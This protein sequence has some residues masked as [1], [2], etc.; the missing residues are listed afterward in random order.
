MRVPFLRDRRTVSLLHPDAT[1]ASDRFSRSAPYGA[2]AY[3]AAWAR[4][5]RRLST[6]RRAAAR[7]GS[8]ASVATP[9]LVA[10]QP[11]DRP[12]T[13]R[14]GARHGENASFFCAMLVPAAS[15]PARGGGAVRWR[16][17]RTLGGPTAAPDPTTAGMGTEMTT[18]ESDIYYDPYDFEIDS[19]PYPVWKRLRDERPLYYNERY[20]FYAVSRFE[21]VD[22]LLDGLEDLH[23]RQGHRPRAD[24]ERHGAAARIDHLRGPSRP[25]PPP[26]PAVARVHAHA[27]S[28]T[29][30]PRSAEFCARSLDPLVGRGGSTSSPTSAPRCPCAPSACCWASPRQDQE[31]IRDR[32]D[33]GL[34]LDRGRHARPRHRLRRGHQCRQRLRRVHRLAGHPPV[35]RPDDRSAPGRVRGRDRAPCAGSPARRSSTTSTSSPPRATRPRPA[36]SDGRARCWPSTPTSSGELAERPQPGARTP[37]RSCCATSPRR[38]SRPATSPA[39][40]S[41]TGR[42]SRPA[43]R[44]CCSPPRRNRDERKFPDADRFDIHRTI[45]HHLAF[46]YGIHFCL[47]VGAG[48]ARGPRR[49]GRGPAALPVV[50]GRLGQCRPGPDLD[51]PGLG[52]AAR[53]HRPDRAATRPRKRGRPTM[54]TVVVGASSGLGRSIA[55]GTRAAGRH[56]RPAGPAEGPPG[57][58]G[59][60]G[61][62]GRVGHRL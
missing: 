38:P 8:T 56:R 45:D 39:T 36:S 6:V 51:G 13:G 2:C 12:R 27:R 24:Q 54:R 16:G 3:R 15:P 17:G 22:Q 29:S 40:S 30:S 47:G 44:S 7:F 60:G 50:G 31:A 37:S 5:C 33:E 26:P 58:R 57:R 55:I 32:I 18:M 61:R 59:R 46:G 19:D 20:D 35:G 53:R 1:P 9:D 25:R 48:P 10:W 34:R 42:P 52:A 21:D 4:R 23:L 43:A 41:T 11:G 49:P 62:A 28:T 14:T